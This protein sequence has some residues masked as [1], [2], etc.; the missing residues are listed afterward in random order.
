MLR[1]YG[2]ITLAF[3]TLS[4]CARTVVLPQEDADAVTEWTLEADR[5]GHGGANWHTLA[6]MHRAMHDAANAADPHYARWA[7]AAADEPQ[8]DAASVPAAIAGAAEVVLTALHPDGDDEI[9]AVYARALGRLP[10]GSPVDRGLVLGRAIGR[11]TLARRAHDGYSSVRPFIGSEAA[12]RWRPTPPDFLTS[13]T[14]DSLPFLF[15][16][17]EWPGERPPPV[18]LSRTAIEDT[19][20]TRDIGG[21]RSAERTPEQTEIARFWAFQSSQRGFVRLAVRLLFTHPRPGGIVEH[22]RI[23]SQLASAMADSAVLTWAEKERYSSW[24]P[25]TVIR[26]GQGVPA[27]PDW[28]PMIETPEHPE[29]P[30]GHATDCYTGAAVLDGV[31]GRRTISPVVYTA[32]EAKAEADPPEMTMGQHVQAG[33]RPSNSRI[34]PSLDAIA[35]ECADSRIRSGAHFRAARDESKRLSDAIA[36]RALAAVPPLADPQ[37]R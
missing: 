23:M 1:Y 20:F 33:T 35:T 19:I 37:A 2:L 15:P 14:T 5:L 26:A 36:A 10:A 21:E 4:A 16:A 24:R 18:P 30:S 11:S 8:H 32:A 17:R 7:A 27:V 22:A 29:Y 9:E 3:L 31:F 28:R 25:I 34:G 13:N 6:I 12:G